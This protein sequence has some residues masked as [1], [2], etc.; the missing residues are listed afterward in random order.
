MGGYGR[1]LCNLY[2]KFL[3]SLC[4]SHRFEA[5]K[6]YRKLSLTYHLICDPYR[7]LGRQFNYKSISVLWFLRRK[8]TIDDGIIMV[9]L[10]AAILKWGLGAYGFYQFFVHCSHSLRRNRMS[11]F[12]SVW[13]AKMNLYLEHL[14][15]NHHC[16]NYTD[17]LLLRS[18]YGA[19]NSAIVVLAEG[20]KKFRHP[21]RFLHLMKRVSAR[22]R[23]IERDWKRWQILKKMA[24][25]ISLNKNCTER[26]IFSWMFADIEGSITT[27]QHIQKLNQ[28]GI[29][30]PPPSGKKLTSVN[31][32]SS[33]KTTNAETQWWL[34]YT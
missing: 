13:D 18:S 16:L 14:G 23:Q 28:W 7:H 20:N 15:Q 24:L 17:F 29:E 31:I 3:L 21:N 34:T 30:R 1:V 2:S 4:L 19:I 27:L 33:A 6:S 32:L 11:A 25:R 26:S 12:K 9:K 10:Y 8:C 22:A 5:A